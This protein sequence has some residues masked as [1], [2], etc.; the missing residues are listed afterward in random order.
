VN[1]RVY[2]A[3]SMEHCNRLA[4]EEQSSSSRCEKICSTGDSVK[5]RKL[6]PIFLNLTSVFFTQLKAHIIT[7]KKGKNKLLPAHIFSTTAKI[8]A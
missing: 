7:T 3:E 8:N 6:R 4:Q 2:T 1:A 5:L